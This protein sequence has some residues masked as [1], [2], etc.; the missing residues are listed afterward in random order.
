MTKIVEANEPLDESV[1]AELEK[2]LNIEL[3]EFYR[4]FLLK[5][6]GGRPVPDGF[7]FKGKTKGSMVDGFFGIHN[8][9]Y[10]NLRDE[11]E[12]YKNRIPYNFF[13]IARDPGDNL[14]AIAV[15]NP[16]KGSIY[17]WNHE[18]ENEIDG[19]YDFS[20]VILIADSFDE[21]LD[22]LYEIQ[23]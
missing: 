18:R 2:S 20:N 22:N 19:S 3:P 4:N 21:F 12:T 6:N 7:K 15:S 10:N 16:N 14:I 9:K 13:P 17:F 23:V 5:Y 1:L 8:Q 11:L